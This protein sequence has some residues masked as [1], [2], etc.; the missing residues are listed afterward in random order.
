MN[1]RLIIAVL[2]GSVVS[3]LL[4]WLIFDILLGAYYESTMN[5]FKGLQRDEATVR[6]WAIYLAQLA[7][8]AL[9]GYV[10]SRQS[11]NYSIGSS[12]VTGA[13]VMGLAGGAFNLMMWATMNLAPYKLYVVD[14]AVNAVFGG[15]IAVIIGMILKPKTV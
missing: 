4:G 6:L 1:M 10:L 14:T 12:F 7:W 13:V 8:C 3:F 15:V 9:L 11:G 5:V 2:I